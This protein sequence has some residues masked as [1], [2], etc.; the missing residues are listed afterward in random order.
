VT[1]EVEMPSGKRLT[2]EVSEWCEVKEN[3]ITSFR[4]YFDTAVFLKEMG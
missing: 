1:T 3:K 2:L 4:A